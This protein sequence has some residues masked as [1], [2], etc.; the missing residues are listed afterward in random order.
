MSV[1]RQSPEIAVLSKSRFWIQNFGI[2]T[3]QGEISPGLA[4]NETR[5]IICTRREPE[6]LEKPGEPAAARKSGLQRRRRSSSRRDLVPGCKGGVE[7]AGRVRGSG[8][9]I[10]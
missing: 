2:F 1:R 5:I 3:A 6:N 9:V 10:S 7:L 8:I 4:A